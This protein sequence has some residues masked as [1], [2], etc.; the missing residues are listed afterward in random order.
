MKTPKERDGELKRA[1]HH[2]TDPA[3][4]EEWA[5]WDKVDACWIGDAKGSMIYEEKGHAVMLAMIL[6]ERMDRPFRYE[7]RR[8]VRSPKKV[9]DTITPKKSAR[10][11]M[12]KLKL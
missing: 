6:G 5:A 4:P 10:E 9:M 8:F 2:E 12:A 7:A 3:T 11:A 1:F